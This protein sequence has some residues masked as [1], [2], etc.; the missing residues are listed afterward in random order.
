MA[1]SAVRRLVLWF[2]IVHA[3]PAKRKGFEV[4]AARNAAR[5]HL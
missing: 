1:T 3:A 5:A 2:P 4:F